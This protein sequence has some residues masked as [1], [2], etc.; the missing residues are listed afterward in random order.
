MIGMIKTVMDVLSWLK[1]NWKM[2][3]LIAV[4]LA[5]FGGGFYVAKRWYA[6]DVQKCDFAEERASMQHEIDELKTNNALIAVQLQQER[7]AR[8]AERTSRLARDK[9]LVELRNRHEAARTELKRL[10]EIRPDVKAWTDLPIPDDLNR[11][12]REQTNVRF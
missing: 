5:A 8:A 4:I 7:I 11:R 9:D 10:K 12:L 2:A 3:I 1:G 6:A